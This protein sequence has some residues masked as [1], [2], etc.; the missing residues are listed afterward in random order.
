MNLIPVWCCSTSEMRA[1][2]TV[3]QDGEGFWGVLGGKNL[4]MDTWPNL[5][6]NRKAVVNLLA[7]KGTVVHQTAMQEPGL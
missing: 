3:A 5:Y 1:L 2:Q 6:M 4:P 7:L